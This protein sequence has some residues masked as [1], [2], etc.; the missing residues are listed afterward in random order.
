MP[1]ENSSTADDMEGQMIAKCRQDGTV[2]ISGARGTEKFNRIEAGIGWPAKED[3]Y[4]CI[5]GERMDGKY[6]L[7]WEIQGGLWELGSQIPEL[8]NR[9]MIDCIRADTDDGVAAAYLRSLNNSVMETARDHG[10]IKRHLGRPELLP[11]IVPVPASMTGSFRS[12]VEQVRGIVMSGKVVI[13]RTNCKRLVTAMRQKVEDLMD[14]S[15]MKAFAWVILGMERSGT[16]APEETSDAGWY[17]NLD[18][19]VWF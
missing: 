3:G 10:E 2:E 4:L 7:L 19:S 17:G 5:A 1:E 18:R 15:V 8:T 9:F 12:A 13:H 14:S 11:P 16:L 6:H